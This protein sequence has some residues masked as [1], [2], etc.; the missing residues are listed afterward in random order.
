MNVFE[1]SFNLGPLQPVDLSCEILGQA[2]APFVMIPS[3]LDGWLAQNEARKKEK[4]LF[5]V[6]GGRGKER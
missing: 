6:G 1:R 2:L 4:A 3:W 5:Q